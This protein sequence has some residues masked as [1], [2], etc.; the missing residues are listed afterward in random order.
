MVSRE[1]YLL[2]EKG[3]EQNRCTIILQWFPIA[4]LVMNWVL[5]VDLQSVLAA[6]HTLTAVPSY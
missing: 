4:H 5:A 3:P 2:L 1:V 6:N